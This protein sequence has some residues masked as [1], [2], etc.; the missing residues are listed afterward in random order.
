MIPPRLISPPE[1]REPLSRREAVFR[2]ACR[3][4]D[5]GQTDSRAMLDGPVT[6]GPSTTTTSIGLNIANIVIADSG[7]P[8]L[9]QAFGLVRTRS[10]L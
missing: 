5:A 4:D 6:P 1:R 10:V 7:R 3:S 8:P 9:G 2:R